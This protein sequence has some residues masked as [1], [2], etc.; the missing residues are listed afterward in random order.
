MGMNRFIY[1]IID[2]SASYS[3]EVILSIL[4]Y[5]NPVYAKILKDTSSSH[6]YTVILTD[7]PE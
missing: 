3:H 5:S 4:F 7:C 6:F 1:H 2:I